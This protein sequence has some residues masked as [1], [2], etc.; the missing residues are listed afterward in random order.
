MSPHR[1]TRK[2]QAIT[3]TPSSGNV[4]ADIGAPEPEKELAKAHARTARRLCAGAQ[5]KKRKAAKR[6]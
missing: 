5:P 3:V 6:P 4:F 1:R 2:Q